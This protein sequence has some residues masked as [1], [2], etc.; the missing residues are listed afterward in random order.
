MLDRLTEAVD[1]S[2]Q[3]CE[4]MQPT[5]HVTRV[6]YVLKDLAAKFNRDDDDDASVRACSYDTCSTEH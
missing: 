2:F 5:K 6:K 3:R 4:N 1:K